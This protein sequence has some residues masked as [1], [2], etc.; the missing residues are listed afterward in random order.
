MLYAGHGLQW[1]DLSGSYPVVNLN[2][3]ETVETLQ[4]IEDLYQSGVL[5]RSDPD[6]D[7]WL[8]IS[9]A[10]TSGQVG[11][12]TAPAGE[13]EKEFFGYSKPDF[14][15]G[16]APLPNTP[17][18]NGPY[19]RNYELGFYISASSEAPQACWELA[20]YI[21]EQADKLDGVPARN[22]VANSP[23]WVD[24]K[25]TETAEVYRKALENSMTGDF[26]FPEM[27]YFWFPIENWW[28]QASQ[29]IRD[30]NNPEQELAAAQQMIDD[31]LDCMASVDVLNLDRH[32]LEEESQACVA[33]NGSSNSSE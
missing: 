6:E 9:G 14:K 4:W 31:Y 22:S 15:V 7:W 33:G 20:R 26:G 32:E 17:K 28:W 18:L 30:G 1:R 25:G 12:W 16:I 3:P 2:T 5:Y 29:N 13:E 10:V 23:A 27:G 11:F 21:T 24:E 19:D 8:S